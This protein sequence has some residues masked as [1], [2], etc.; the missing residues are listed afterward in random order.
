M[1]KYRGGCGPV[2]EQQRSKKVTLQ[3]T[4][5]V[6]KVKSSETNLKAIPTCKRQKS[7]QQLKTDCFGRECS[8]K[9]WSLGLPGWR[10]KR[11]DNVLYPQQLVLG[12]S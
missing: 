4:A 9:M 12:Y 8:R 6:R 11:Q 7:T 10:M 2:L 1:A 3:G 5:V